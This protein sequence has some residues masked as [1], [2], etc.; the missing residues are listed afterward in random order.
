MSHLVPC[1]AC[2]RH[3][4]SGE[5]ECPFCGVALDLSATPARPMPCGRLGRTALFAFGAAI[6]GATILGCGSDDSSGSGGTGG[7]VAGSGSAAG[8]AGQ[9]GAAGSGG[10]AGM[11]GASGNGGTAASQPIY[12]APPMP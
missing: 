6:A 3:V 2:D 5:S 1:P 11:A 9:A 8:D 10:T 7:G 4:R 12:G